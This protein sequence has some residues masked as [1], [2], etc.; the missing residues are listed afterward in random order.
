MAMRI[1]SEVVAAVLLLAMN[2]AVAEPQRPLLISG[3]DDVLRQADNTS[4]VRAAIKTMATDA[5]FAGM[6]QLYRILADDPHGA[7][8]IV[9]SATSSWFEGGARRFLHEAKYPDADLHLRNWLTDWSAHDFKAAR[10]R[11]ILSAHPDRDFIL[12]LDNSPTSAR[13]VETLRKEFS[14][15]L[16]AVYQRTTVEREP[17]RGATSFIT[18]FDIAI[19]ELRAGRMTLDELEEVASAIVNEASGENIVPGYAYC[20]RDFDP[21]SPAVQGAEA[22]CARVRARIAAVCAAGLH[23]GA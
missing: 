14:K 7:R 23:G 10:I 20:P 21:C 19:H 9:V 12:V 15:R 16:I 17:P 18:A 1:R 4:F 8:F 11:A 22:T 3:Y 2:V 13:L 6:P 5:T